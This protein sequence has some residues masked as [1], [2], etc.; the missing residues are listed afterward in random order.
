MLQPFTFDS[1]VIGAYAADDQ[2]HKGEVCIELNDGEALAQVYMT[3]EEAEKL[4]DDLAREAH[5]A[6]VRVLS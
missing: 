4:A 1:S 3:P 6:R 2:P 5:L